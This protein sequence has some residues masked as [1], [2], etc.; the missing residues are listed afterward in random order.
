[1][2]KKNNTK[3]IWF[4]CISAVLA[5]FIGVILWLV[6][7][8]ENNDIFSAIGP[9]FRGVSIGGIVLYALW[10]FIKS[11][12]TS[13]KGRIIGIKVI[14]IALLEFAIIGLGIYFNWGTIGTLIVFVVVALIG[15]RIKIAVDNTVC[16]KCGKKFAMNE[17]SRKTVNSCAT[18]IDIEQKIRNTRGVVTGTY[19]QP[20]PA[21]RYVYACVDECKFCKHQQEVTREATY[22]D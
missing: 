22:R 8:A 13:K 4:V 15:L 17:V 14:I 10:H 1:M 6:G 7:I 16:P 19:T 9:I 5:M 3:S 20:V 18:T 2:E 21:T 11:M 12:C